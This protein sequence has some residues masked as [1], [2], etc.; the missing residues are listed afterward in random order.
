MFTFGYSKQQFR[1]CYLKVFYFYLVDRMA[2][3]FPL[4]KAG[5]QIIVLFFITVNF[6]QA[7]R[8][9]HQDEDRIKSRAGS[10]VMIVGTNETQYPQG[11]IPLYEKY[12]ITFQ[13]TTSAQ[14]LQL[15]FDLTPPPGIDP[16]IGVSVDAYFSPDNWKTVHTQPGFFY[17]EFLDEIKSGKEWF[18]PSGEL[19]WKVRFAPSEVGTWQYKIRVRDSSGVAE[20]AIGSFQVV[21]SKNR[22]FVRVSQKDERYFEFEDGSY[23]PGLGYNMNFD[24]VSWTNPTLDNLENF[25]RMSQNGIQL[26]R[27]WLSEWGIYG[28]SWNPWN[29]IDPVLHG[30]YIPY[31]GMTFEEVYPGSQVSMKINTSRNPCMFIGWLKAKPA[32]QQDTDY[33]IRIRYKTS[34]VQGPAT[35]GRPF[36]FVAKTGGW[37]G[38]DANNCQNPGTGTV[39]SDYQSTDTDG[40]QVLEGRFNSQDNDFLPN[41]YLVME[42][43]LAGIAYVDYVWIEEDLGNGDYGPN[44]ISK[45]WMA[46]HLYMEQRNSYAFDKVVELAEQYGI[47]LKIVLLEKNDWIF[48]RLNEQGAPIPD[49][50]LCSDDDQSN[51][52]EEC[53]AN[54]WF[55]GAWRKT[56]A[57]RWYQQAWWRYVQARWGYS[58]SVHSWELLNE[59]DPFSSRHYALADEFGIYMHQFAPNHHLVTTSN[60]HSF[61]VD[62]FWGNSTYPNVDY[63][64]YHVYIS[65]HDPYFSDTATAVYDLSMKIGAKQSRGPGK[66]VM[67]GEIG[68]ESQDKATPLFEKDTQAVWLHKFIWGG[69]NPGGVLESYWYDQA[70]IYSTDKKGNYLYD[71]RDHFGRYFNFIQSEPLNN[72]SYREPTVLPSNETLRVWGQIDEV[73]QRAH[74]WIQNTHHTWR[75]VVDAHNIPA[76]TGHVDIFGFQPG[77]PFTLQWWDTYATDPDLQIISEI[78]AIANQEGSIRLEVVELFTDV[79]VKIIPRYRVLLPI[80]P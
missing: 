45:P 53:P 60:W 8:L 35:G 49:D 51:N 28:P 10:V 12:E 26:V 75:N 42:N 74:L 36:G 30:R 68:F 20:S 70:H 77:K 21:P 7:H 61:P 4:F 41:F 58:T 44:I 66:P 37:L 59:G 33:R 78:S 24:H 76:V 11:M 62:G 39:V 54:R 64:N 72:G 17:Q 2:M 38:G 67:R 73:N 25:Q 40:W 32:V 3:N 50:P 55:Y 19:V 6:A 69:I 31:S 47:F 34:G 48:N 9:P 27:I 14:N 46:H 22:G 13:I 57:V 5:I 80:C 56:T 23:F 65:E 79:A 63:A 52:P 1:R 43:T 29:S 15:P 16:G 18:Y 71:F